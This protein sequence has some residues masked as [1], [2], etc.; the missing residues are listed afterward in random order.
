MDIAQEPIFVWLAQFAY[1]PHYV[2]LGLVGMMLASAFGLPVPEEVT[3]VSVGILTFMGTRPDLFPPPYPGAPVINVHE[4]ALLAFFSVFLSDFLIYGIG[5]K[6][7][8]PILNHPRT[9]KFITEEMVNRVERWTKKYGPVACFI[10]RFTPGIRFPGHLACGILR[11][12]A[13]KF[14][15]IDGLAALISV[16]TQIYLLAWYGESVLEKFKEFKIALFSIFG[17]VII[18]LVVRKILKK[19]PEPQVA[20]STNESHFGTK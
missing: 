3:L 6:W 11:F 14:L 20:S 18:F 16:P 15:A 5:R 19:A 10:F 2:Y 8:R 17:L 12:E 1:Q 7:G 4:A 9:R 13:W